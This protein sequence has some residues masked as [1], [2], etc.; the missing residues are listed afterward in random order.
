[1]AVA[2]SAL[3][4]GVVYTIDW[5][6]M[7]RV[8]GVLIL[9]G[10]SYL[11]AAGLFFLKKDLMDRVRVWADASQRWSVVSLNG[12]KCQVK[13]PGNAVRD[14]GQPL[15]GFAEMKEG[16]Q[17]LFLPDPPSGPRYEYRFAVGQPDGARKTV[18][19]AWFAHVGEKLQQNARGGRLIGDPQTVKF[20]NG[21]G[22]EWTFDVGDATR[23]VRVYVVGDRVYYLYVEGQNLTPTDEE[24]VQPFFG[25]FSVN[26]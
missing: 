22:R 13:M 18:D 25:T 8:K 11:S 26:N 7:T 12:G 9:V 3:C 24:H 15:N 6:A 16:R 17:S 14:D 21:V 4:L 5:T 2:A 23:I 19:D 10:L 20:V 1:M